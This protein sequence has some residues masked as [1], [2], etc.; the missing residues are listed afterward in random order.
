MNQMIKAGISP[1]RNNKIVEVYIQQ[2]QMS[3]HWHKI[4][5]EYTGFL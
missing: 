3:I 2:N 5:T 4:C 1:S